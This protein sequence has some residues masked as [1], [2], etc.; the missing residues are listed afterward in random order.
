MSRRPASLT[1]R[2]SLLFGLI[3]VV[4]YSAFG[5][6]IEDSIKRHFVG[7]DSN[8]MRE[9]A[10][11]ATEVLTDSAPWTDPE[12]LVGRLDGMMVGHELSALYITD[13]DGNPLY[14]SANPPLDMTPLVSADMAGASGEVRNWM[15]NGHEFRVLTRQVD[16]AHG[17]PYRLAVAL[18][19]DYHA[20]FLERFRYTLWLMVFSGTLITAFLGWVAVRQGHAPLRAIV[21]QIRQ[22][23]TDELDTRLAPEQVPRE[24]SS[25]ANS[26]ND[27]LRRLESGFNRLSHYSAD[28]AH[29]LRTPVTS[30]LTQTQVAL[31]QSR[32]VEEYREIL[33]S[34]MEEYEHMAQ[35]IADMLFLAQADNALK[36]SQK[37]SVDLRA[38]WMALFDYFEALAEESGVSLVCYGE[39]RVMADRPM[40][41]R[42]LSNLLANAIRH[43]A[44]G[45]TVTVHLG[46]DA[47]G[48]VTISVENPG[49]DIPGEH[50]DHLF[51][52]FYSADASRR[53]SGV[54]LGLA[55][56][57]S[58]VEAHGGTIGVTSSAGRTCFTVTMPPI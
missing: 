12:L 47:R 8:E 4:V 42:A 44:G 7:E 13:A 34:N 31:T 55:I 3:A 16:G 15:D 9:V 5:W 38:E 45:D 56:T 11:A 33:Y 29:E 21:E 25:L 1:F 40:F 54:G 18:S 17:A 49:R 52:R 23:N 50:L 27:M 14:H 43:T 26:F 58:I 28:I 24:L 10:Q 37:I 48:S 2:L 6:F 32:S 35:M 36:D 51:D 20:G 39:A 22:V 41:Q 53:S 57:K 46:Q 30:L 19:M